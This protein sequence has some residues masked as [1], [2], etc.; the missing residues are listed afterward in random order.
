VGYGLLESLFALPKRS[1]LVTGL[2][3]HEGPGLLPAESIPAEEAPDMATPS[4]GTAPEAVHDPAPDAS[5]QDQILEAEPV[6]VDAGDLKDFVGQPPFT[7]DRIY[8][9]TPPGVVMGLAWCVPCPHFLAL[10]QGCNS[11]LP[12]LQKTLETDLLHDI[13]DRSPC[14]PASRYFGYVGYFG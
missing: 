7:S 3:G 6:R 1:A 12:V 2:E 9:V 4:T 8:D 10:Q 11:T 5:T 13:I 14:L